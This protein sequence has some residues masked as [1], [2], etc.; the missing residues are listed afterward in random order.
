MKTEPSPV[1]RDQLISI[2]KMLVKAKDPIALA[3][4]KSMRHTRKLK[5]WIARGKNIG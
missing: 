1:T 5:E 3:M 2:H 4:E